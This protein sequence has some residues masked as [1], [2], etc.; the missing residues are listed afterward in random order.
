MPVWRLTINVSY[1]RIKFE[2]KLVIK[3]PTTFS[4][5]VKI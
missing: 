2:R 3:Q 1:K 5:T 4:A